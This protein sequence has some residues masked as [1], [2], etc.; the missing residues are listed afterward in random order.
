MRS[1]RRLGLLLIVYTFTALVSPGSSIVNPRPK[2]TYQP[3]FVFPSVPEHDRR[4]LPIWGLSLYD[5][6]TGSSNQRLKRQMQPTSSVFELESTDRA[7]VEASP[8]AARAKT[9]PRNHN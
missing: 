3:D 4:R 7:S 2:P 5:L 8:R 6:S 1:L 9:T